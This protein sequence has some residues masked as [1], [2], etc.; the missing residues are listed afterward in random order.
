MELAAASAIASA[1]IGA[2][3]SMY[4]GRAQASADT[5]NAQVA[6]N[7]ARSA[8]EMARADLEQKAREQQKHFGAVRAAYGASG[9]AFDGSALDV[10]EDQLLDAELDKRM[11]TYKGELRARGFEDE[12]KL[13]RMSA[14]SASTAGFIGALSSFARA[15]ASYYGNRP[16]AA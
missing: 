14:K 13:R 12:A 11:I 15:G 2:V 10:F 4:Q 16:T 6:E 1:A 3:G 5:F 8:R 9:I 7:N